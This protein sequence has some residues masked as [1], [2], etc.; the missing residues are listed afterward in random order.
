MSAAAG[1]VLVAAPAAA[2]K[3]V[4]D[5]DGQGSATNCN[6][7]AAAYFTISTALAAANPGD[8]IIICPGPLDGL[9]DEQLTIDKN[10]TLVGKNG[11]GIRPSPMAANSTSLTSGFPIAAAILIE[12]GTA[13]VEIEQ[14][15]IDGS[16]HGINGCDAN[17]VGVY[18]RNASGSVVNSVVKNIR[19]G[20]GFGGCQAGLAIFAQSGDGGTSEVTVNNTSVHDFQKNG[21]TGN[22][23]GT[24]LTAINNK[25]TGDGPT[26]EIAQNGIQIGFGATGTVTGNVVSEV[27]WS[28][29]SAPSDPDCQNGSSTGILIYQ[30]SDAVNVSGNTITTTQTGIYF[31]V[32]GGAANS[33][34][35]TRTKVYDGI[36][37]PCGANGNTINGNTITNSDESGI[38]VDGAVNTITKNRIS[39][40]PIGVH[41]ADTN[42]VPTG[43]GKNTFLNVPV[44]LDEVPSACET[45]TA[46]SG[47]STTAPVVSPAK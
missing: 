43:N 1:V 46:L 44:P 34:L 5:D 16:D 9:Y 6:A 7:S 32:P 10:I 38:W 26:T 2:A 3:R 17:P 14:L 29:C 47:S 39:E 19:L 25:V 35:I 41:H 36:Y 23:S 22:E 37:L 4:V 45:E 42:I 30:S 24:T 27:V 18:Y 13:N 33:N 28:P 31:D 20:A 8:Q 11:A 21:I 15:T 12:D 40:A